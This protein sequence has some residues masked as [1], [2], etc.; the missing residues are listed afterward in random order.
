MADSKS[1]FLGGH[2]QVAGPFSTSEIS[3]MRSSGKIAQYTYIWDDKKESWINLDPP[4]PHPH[5]GKSADP[6]GWE[7]V[8][9]GA[10]R[11]L[12]GGIKNVG[13]TGCELVTSQTSGTPELS[14]RGSWTLNVLD[15]S[16]LKAINVKAQISSAFVEQGRWVYRITWAARP[17][18]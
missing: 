14:A 2:G 17:E 7:A 10:G 15:R 11:I 13:P 1:V 8:C 16:T 6:S 3:E 12:A 9:F 4:P 5:S 18:L